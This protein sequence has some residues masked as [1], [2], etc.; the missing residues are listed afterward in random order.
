MYKQMRIFQSGMSKAL[1]F[2]HAKFVNHSFVFGWGVMSIL[3]EGLCN[4]IYKSFQIP[5]YK[6]KNISTKIKISKL[7]S[8]KD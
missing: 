2:K 8:Y 4:P 5:L 7:L 3:F 6:L 1:M